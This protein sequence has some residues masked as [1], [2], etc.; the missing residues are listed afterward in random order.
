M[1]TE[2][3]ETK[4]ARDRASA[5]RVDAGGRLA[6]AE[7]EVERLQAELAAARPMAAEIRALLAAARGG[8]TEPGPGNP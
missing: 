8:S 5:E 3:A 7:A 4:A 1:T 6:G 2:L